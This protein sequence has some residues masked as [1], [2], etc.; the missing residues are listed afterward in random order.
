M[1]CHELKQKAQEDEQ[2][3]SRNV[4][5]SFE[6]SELEVPV[7]HPRKKSRPHQL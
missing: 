3:W 1:G 4:E 7:G 5:F 6:H 2:V